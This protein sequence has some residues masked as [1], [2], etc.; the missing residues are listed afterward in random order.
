M[1]RVGAWPRRPQEISKQQV[2]VSGVSIPFYRGMLHLLQSTYI[3]ARIE[4]EFSRC[5]F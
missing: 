4:F 3:E 2:C 5:F 1:L